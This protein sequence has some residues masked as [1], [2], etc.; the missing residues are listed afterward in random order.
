MTGIR[1]WALTAW[2]AGLLTL[3][4][5]A[6]TSD[7]V[8]SVSGSSTTHSKELTPEQQVE[9]V[10]KRFQERWDAMIAKDYTKAY[11]YLSPA[12]RELVTEA[13]F[14]ARFSK[15]QFKK[16]E[17]PEVKCEEDVCVVR[18]ML[19]YDH[20]VMRGIVTPTGEKW[21]FLYGEAWFNLPE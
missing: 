20:A 18:F 16:A 3:A 15:G 9:I 1:K 11:S 5:C 19:T 2:L 21:L 7:S 12:T 4:G 13:Q 10:K 8:T 6:T 14:V 17:Q